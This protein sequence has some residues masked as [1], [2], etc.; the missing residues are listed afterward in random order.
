MIVIRIALCIIVP[1]LASSPAKQTFYDQAH[2][3]SD[4]NAEEAHATTTVSSNTDTVAATVF[5]GIDEATTSLVSGSEI[6]A[7]TTLSHASEEANAP[8]S[9]SDS[10]GTPTSSSPI[11]ES[12][13]SQMV[14]IDDLLADFNSVTLIILPGPFEDLLD[15]DSDSEHSP[16]QVTPASE[17]FALASPIFS[18]Q[19]SQNSE[20]SEHHMSME[21]FGDA[22]EADETYGDFQMASVPYDHNATF[23][24]SDDDSDDGTISWHRRPTPPVYIGTPNLRASRFIQEATT[25]MPDDTV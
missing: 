21:D 2:D 13:S 14:D 16:I 18:R 6:A 3:Y 9:S 8:A 24:D 15:M 23:V 1:I 4:E 12:E 22:F 19:E 25:T 20:Y 10:V 17:T 7:T 11:E 5:P